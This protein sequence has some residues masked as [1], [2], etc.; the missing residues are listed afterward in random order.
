M[1]TRTL[2]LKRR[3]KFEAQAVKNF[4]TL[5][6]NYMY[7]YLSL[8]AVYI[9]NVYIVQCTTLFISKTLSLNLCHCFK[10]E[11]TQIKTQAL[12]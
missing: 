2:G 7:M 5:Q 12:H 1:K 6:Y 3:E 4:K 8:I 9:Y 10:M 11:K